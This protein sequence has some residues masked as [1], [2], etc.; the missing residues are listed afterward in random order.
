MYTLFLYDSEYYKTFDTKIYGLYQQQITTY[1]D[2][3]NDDKQQTT[4]KQQ[5]QKLYQILHSQ[6]THQQLPTSDLTVFQDGRYYCQRH[7]R[8][9][10]QRHSSN[11]RQ[12]QTK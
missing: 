11:S 4:D 8:Y 9:Y 6:Q 2:Q 10:C 5:I 7:G 1:N 3:I 12:Y